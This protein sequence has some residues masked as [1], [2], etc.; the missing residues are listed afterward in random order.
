MLSCVVNQDVNMWQW[1]IVF[2]ASPIQIP[3]VHAHSDFAILLRHGHNVRNPLWIGS[4]IQ[5]ASVE[6]LH[7]LSFD[8][9]RHVG[10][11]SADP[12]LDRW[13]VFSCRETVDHD[14]C[15]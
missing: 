13:T 1:K 4:N 3:I 5:K 11:H 10:P 7:Y 9:L 2:R 12:L 15:V 8:L 6:L 14:I